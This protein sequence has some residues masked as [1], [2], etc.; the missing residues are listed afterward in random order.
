MKEVKPLSE[1]LKESFEWYQHNIDKVN[2]K[3]FFKYID[4]NMV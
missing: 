1:G 3:P 4:N 2:K